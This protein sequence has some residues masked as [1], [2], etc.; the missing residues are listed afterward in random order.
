[1]SKDTHVPSYRRHKQSGQAIVTLP[2][3]LGGRRDR[4]L[5]KYGTKQS[6][7]EYARVIFLGPQAQEVLKPFLDRDPEAYLFC[8]REMME[9]FRAKQRRERKSKV[10]PSQVNR[11]KRRPKKQPGCRYT[12]DSYRRAID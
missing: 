4:L 12:V 9:A 1:M 2:D 3:G 7:M 8:P 11:K 5:G 10:Q 6:R